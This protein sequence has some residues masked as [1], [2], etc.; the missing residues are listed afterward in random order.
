MRVYLS[1][2]R[3]SINAE[4]KLL[5]LDEFLDEI[6]EYSHTPSQTKCQVTKVKIGIK[7]RAEETDEITQ[8]TLGTE[9]RNISDGV[10][11]SLFLLETLQRNPVI[12]FKTMRIM[13]FLDNGLIKSL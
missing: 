3:V 10:A 1:A 13:D 7:K 5:P 9:L 12:L 4:V 8:Q 11:A 6:H 2:K